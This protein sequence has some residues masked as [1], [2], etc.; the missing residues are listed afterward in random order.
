MGKGKNHL[1]K[2]YPVCLL[3]FFSIQLFPTVF[4]CNEFLPVLSCSNLEHREQC[5]F[6]LEYVDS[7]ELLSDLRMQN[8]PGSKRSKA[9]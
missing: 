1:K 2:L 4:P 7:C 8:G 3:S 5:L 9:K 6:F